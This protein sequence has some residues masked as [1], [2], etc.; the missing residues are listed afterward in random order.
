[1][2]P[3]ELRKRI[4]GST[5]LTLAAEAGWGPMPARTGKKSDE[6]RM[7][8]KIAPSMKALPKALREK[9]ELP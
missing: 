2:Q 4:V 3:P 5:P 6:R 7:A 8:P 9:T 1:V